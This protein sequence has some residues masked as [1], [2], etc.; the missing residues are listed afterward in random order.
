MRYQF[1][2]GLIPTLATVLFFPLFISLGL[3][4]VDRAQEKNLM[5]EE[6]EQRIDS[7]PVD[8]LE[9]GQ[10][11]DLSQWNWQPVNVRGQFDN[12]FVILLDNQTYAGRAG[13]QVLMPF[14]YG[15]NRE[16]ILVNRGWMAMDGDRTI[17]PDIEPIEGV[18]EIH[19]IIK[20]VPFTGLGHD[21]RQIEQLDGRTYRVQLISIEN[22]SLKINRALPDLIL[23]LDE[24]SGFSLVKNWK[25]PGSGAA[26]HYGYAFQWFAFSA[27]LM[28]LYIYLN[29]KKVE[30]ND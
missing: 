4:Q 11:L 14:Y 2:P 13:Y 28:F 19:G 12:R 24:Q 3:W 20:N 9:I 29:L 23:R 26:K 5:Y 1:V 21:D 30:K 10:P 25:Q 18:V 16:V 27:V 22:L 6:F 15:D 7:T 17:I 8:L